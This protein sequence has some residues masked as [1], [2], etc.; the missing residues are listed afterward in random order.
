[1]RA[2]AFFVKS[3]WYA[4]SFLPAPGMVPFSLLKRHFC[5]LSGL[6]VA[7]S[8]YKS[9]RQ[10]PLV[11]DFVRC[12]DEDCW[13]QASQ[14]LGCIGEV[15]VGREAEV[16][17]LRKKLHLSDTAEA[18]VSLS[19]QKRKLLRLS[20]RTS[21]WHFSVILLD[22]TSLPVPLAS[23][24]ASVSFLKQLPDVVPL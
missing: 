2:L 5:F 19:K 23:T 3:W 9:S 15:C 4:L 10:Y 17:S 8:V 11:F 21:H 1:M 22:H 14:V 13:C 20:Q 16:W 6:G 12:V 24:T 18:L 7:R